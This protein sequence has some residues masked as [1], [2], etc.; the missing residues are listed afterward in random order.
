M[1]RKARRSR[2]GSKALNPVFNVLS[3]L[4]L[5]M[6]CISLLCVG[7]LFAVPGLIPASLQPATEPFIFVVAL[8]PIVPAT[9]TS[10]G[11]VVPTFPAT[12]TPTAT[13]LPS[14]IPPTRTP[15][16]IPSD[17]EPGPTRTPSRTLTPTPTNTGPTPTAS[18]TRSP[19]PWTLQPGS[20]AY[21]KNTANTAGCNW[22]GITG[23]AIDLLGKPVLGYS[24]HLD[25]GGLTVDAVTG[26]KPAVGPGGYEIVLSDHP[27]E[28][29]NTYRVQ[30][31]NASGQPLSDTYVIPTFGE[32]DKN[33]ILVNFVQNH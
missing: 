3:M 16:P 8:S 5:V 14:A 33:W 32:C 22:M 28:T 29:T 9:N 24:V 20:P 10:G 15:S 23:Q 2:R 17:T 7:A 13:P 4:L 30:L 21:L 26:A 19:N 31:R 27:I 11:P 6:S 25:G 18:K 1:E 12:W